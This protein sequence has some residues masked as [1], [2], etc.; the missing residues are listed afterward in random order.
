MDWT[1]VQSFRIVMVGY[2]V[3]R[4]TKKMMA[5]RINS[6]MSSPPQPTRRVR[7]NRRRRNMIS[8]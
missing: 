1:N 6:T 4:E 5:K 3:I 8:P 2:T 7:M